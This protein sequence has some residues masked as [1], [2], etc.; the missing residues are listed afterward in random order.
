MKY[1]NTDISK[2]IQK[3]LKE[4]CRYLKDN[5]IGVLFI[6]QLFGNQNDSKLLEKYSIDNSMILNEKYSSDIQQEVISKL[7]MLV[8]MRYH[9]NIFAAKQGVPFIPIIYEE[10]MSGFLA[11]SGLEKYGISVDELS[12]DKL[13]EMTQKVLVDQKQYRNQLVKLR[14]SWKQSALKT[15]ESLRG[16][17][18]SE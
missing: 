10:K 2:K 1:K 11:D 6:P 4:Y 8:G 3:E 15:K 9:S 7:S 17:L 18:L 13:I 16:Y 14:D 5:N 12:A